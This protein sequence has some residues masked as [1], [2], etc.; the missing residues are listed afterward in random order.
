MIYL[1]SKST[2]DSTHLFAAL[3]RLG[4]I[5]IS[6]LSLVAAVVTT[7][8]SLAYEN[9]DRGVIAINCPNGSTILSWRFL[10]TDLPE[11]SF[12]V[13]KVQDGK[14]T[15]LTGQP[16]SKSCTFIDYTTGG[17]NVDYEIWTIAKGKVVE[18]SKPTY[19]VKATPTN[20][21]IR[22]PLAG[23]YVCDKVGIADIDGDGKLDFV[24]KQPA[25]I[26]DPGVWRPSITTFKVEAY[27]H[28]GKILWRRDLGWNIEQGVWYSPMIVYD[29]DGDGRAE[30]A[31]KTAPVDVDYRDSLGHV[32]RGPEW[33]SVLDG[34]T[35]AELARVDWPPRGNI[36][37]WGDSTGNRASRNTMSIAYLD[38]KTPSLIVARGTYTK[39]IVRAYRFK[40]RQLTLQWEWDGDNENPP[41]RGQGMHGMHCVDVD[42]D[43][44]DEIVLGAAALDDNG[45][46]LWNL[47]MGHPDIVYVTDVL[48]TS[49]GLEIVYGFETRQQSNGICIVDAATGKILWGCKHPTSHVHSQGIFGKFDP[50]NPGYVLY[51]GEKFL[52]N[53]WYYRLNDGQ[54]LD[55]SD[56]GALSGYP[57]YWDE[58][59][60]KWV[61][62]LGAIKRLREEPRFF[63]QGRVIAVAD[64][65]GDWREELIT[66]VP[67]ELRI[68][69]T[70]IPAN[71]RRVTLWH[72][73]AYRIDVANAAMGYLFPPQISGQPLVIQPPKKQNHK[74]GFIKIS[75]LSSDRLPLHSL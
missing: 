51:C 20:A 24:I 58:T 56:W 64:C 2:E 42:G 48:A 54:L 10:S 59:D 62:M 28:G 57:V 52:P 25:S 66:T 26:T 38:G 75:T 39:M 9:L 40:D 12:A 37:D 13:Y 63:Y 72:D 69:V 61:A 67:G 49:P 16:L 53:R 41:V 45:K 21:F 60:I 46:L 31:L 17:T 29:L 4:C 19:T 68:Y 73:R 7:T 18:R 34:L 32:L 44:R 1:R 15:K 22:I 36:Q 43:G 55:T 50:Q 14:K 27:S 11:T 65:I 47:G 35:G 70:T 8:S 30:V 6:L 23:G 74:Q 71:T 5:T 33:L 3:A